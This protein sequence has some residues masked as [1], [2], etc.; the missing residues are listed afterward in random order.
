[1]KLCI[2]EIHH[3]ETKMKI[4]TD[5]RDLIK[6]A[7]N[8]LIKQRSFLEEYILHDPL[9]RV[10]LEPYEIK[11]NSPEI[12]K[13]M[14][15]AAK[16]AGVGPMAAVAGT[17]SEFVCR[18]LIREGSGIAVVENGGDIFAYAEYPI[19][20]GVF[21]GKRFTEELAF[22][23]NRENTP[24]AICSSSSFLGHSLSF[25]EC[26]LAIVF[27]GKA[28]VADAV[29]T[30]V[31]NSVKKEEDIKKVLEWAIKL[32]YVDGVIIIKNNKIGMIGDIPRIIRTEDK[33]IREKI[34]K[35]DIY[36]L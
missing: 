19:K 30:S 32:K 3:K 10:T 27:S 1:M 7:Y 22:E 17:L 28:A 21:S 26:D 24:L 12:I 33:K 5:K 36:R 20:I 34:T 11:E 6:Y 23:L 13:Q 9:F 2:E 15:E 18:R 31:C 25:G 14:A 8:E 4:L 16:I 35:N 29:A